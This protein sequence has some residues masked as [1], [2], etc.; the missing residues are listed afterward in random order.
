[1]LGIADQPE[2]CLKP[3]DQEEGSYPPSDL[4]AL[5]QD[6]RCNAGREGTTRAHRSPRG[7]RRP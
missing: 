7:V 1:M 6:R 5:K 2:Q 4:E 3:V